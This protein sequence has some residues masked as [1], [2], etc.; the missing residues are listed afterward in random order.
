MFSLRPLNAY[1]RR[2]SGRGAPDLFA[3]AQETWEVAPGSGRYVP[4]ALFLPGQI[5][6]IRTTEF[7]PLDMVAKAFRGDYDTFE[8]ATIGARFRNVD[9]VDGV[10]YADGAQ[11]HLRAK[12]SRPLAY[13]VPIEVMSGAMYESWVGNRWFGNWLSDDTMAYLLAETAGTVVTTRTRRTGHVPRYEEL[14]GMDPLR[15]DRVH[16]DELILFEDLPHNA[17]KSRRCAEV[18][19]RLLAGRRCQST[20]GVF[21]LRGDSGDARVMTNER[22]IADELARTYGFHVLDPATATVDE[23]VELCGHAPVVAG[24]EGSHLV[25]GLVVMPPQATLLAFQPPDRTVAALKTI[26]DRQEQRYAFIVGE[27]TSDAFSVDWTEVRRTL[28]LIAKA[29]EPRLQEVAVVGS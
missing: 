18:R 21:L 15:R 17:G 27:G 19:R 3:V 23:I 25:H 7:A 29:G 11:R 8:D 16:F 9:L 24:V 14:L 2:L 28:D 13:R 10:L 6:R 1:L 5:E 12:S 26:T 20:A 4:P 22:Q